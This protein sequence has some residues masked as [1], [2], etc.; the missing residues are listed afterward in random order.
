V[1]HASA[2]PLVKFLEW[3]KLSSPRL[4]AYVAANPFS[5][6][7]N[8][9]LKLNRNVHDGRGKR[10]REDNDEYYDHR[11]G[12]CYKKY[13]SLPPCK[14]VGKQEYVACKLGTRLLASLETASAAQFEGLLGVQA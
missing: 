3:V 12:A 1:S 10:N 9:S 4:R 5:D 7:S 2:C 14:S 11:Y 13:S 8:F 6:S